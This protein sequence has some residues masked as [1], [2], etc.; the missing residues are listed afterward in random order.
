MKKYREVFCPICQKKYMTYV[1]DDDYDFVISQG[2]KTLY[3]W[4]DECPK[5]ETSLFIED[6]V[7]EGRIMDDFDE[8][9]IQ[10]KWILR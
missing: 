10:E 1:Y 5:C 8:K 7:L 2:S 4:R 3:G 6:H 9:D